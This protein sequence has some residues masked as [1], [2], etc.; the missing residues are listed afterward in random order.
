MAKTSRRLLR[1]GLLEACAAK[2]LLDFELWPRQRDLLAAVEAGPRLGVWAVGRRSGK[3]T[4]AAIVALWD[5]LLRPE[6]DEMVRPGETR[7]AV[8]V[9]T[10]FAQA[11]ILLSAARTIVEASPGLAP[12]IESATEDEI[13]FE[14]PSGARTALKAMP[15]SSRGARGWPISCLVLD[16][17]AHFVSE[18]DGYQTAERVWGAL[19]PATAQFGAAARVLAISTPYGESGLFAD[20]YRRAASGDL[21][22]AQ[23]H[24]AATAAVNPTISAEF[25]AQEEA[26]D[27]DSY[28]AEYLAE[29]LGSGDAY[30]DFERIPLLGHP[31]ADPE[32][33]SDWVAGLDPAFARDPF[34]VALVGRS[35]ATEGE[36]IVG[37]VLALKPEGEFAVIDEIAATCLRYGARAVTDQ[38]S[39]AAVVDRLRQHGVDVRVNSMS[40]ESKT[41]I[42]SEMRARLYDGTVELPDHPSLI[43][44]LRRLRTH[45][46][47]GSAAVRNPRLGGSHGDQAQALAMAIYE[48]RGVALGTVISRS[49]I[50]VNADDVEI[51]HSA[52]LSRQGERYLDIG[53]DGR[54]YPPPGW[55]EAE[56]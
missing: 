56:R 3:T 10:N 49:T 30:L 32:M 20:L 50:P 39:A 6:L 14:L 1:A 11:R 24:H 35:R 27:P 21:A 54:R 42:F 47:A 48:Q 31:P 13:R 33:G 17:A 26:R 46:R 8:C 44:E 2:R 23:A 41:A 25:L 19:L 55:S 12:L 22:G 53:D 18:T 40:A 37:P 4:L 15:C 45:F 36:L 51:E 9:A 52:G 43:A 16:E 29:F 5:A 38:Y 34:G 7:F 28:R